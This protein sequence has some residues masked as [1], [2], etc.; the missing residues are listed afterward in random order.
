[1]KT[2]PCRM[3]SSRAGD[4]LA[5][6][7]LCQ[8]RW[9]ER[10]EN[11]RLHRELRHRC[12]ELETI[13]K[14]FDELH[15]EVHDLFKGYNKQV[16]DVIAVNKMR[17]DLRINERL[18]TILDYDDDPP[19]LHDTVHDTVIDGDDVLDTLDS[20]SNSMLFFGSL[21]P[22]ANTNT[23]NDDF[24]KIACLPLAMYAMYA[25]GSDMGPD[26]IVPALMTLV[27]AIMI[28]PPCY[29]ILY[30]YSNLS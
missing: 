30:A 13:N 14:H 26:I 22:T 8:I 7:I 17:F 19:T 23:N 9:R 15:G 3:N 10:K 28:T 24:Y 6:Q 4:V 29:C 18:E 27:N 20:N 21:H 16:E 2:R 25:I 11:Q 12:R 1:M 5:R